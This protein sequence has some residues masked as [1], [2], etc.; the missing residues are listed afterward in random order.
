MAIYFAVKMV[1]G[2]PTP[3]PLPTCWFLWQFLAPVYLMGDDTEIFI[4]V[5]KEEKYVGE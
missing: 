5:R 4:F 2:T 1:E 3:P